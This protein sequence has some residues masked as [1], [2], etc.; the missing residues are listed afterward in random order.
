MTEK[1]P[2][3]LEHQPNGRLAYFKTG[4]GPP[5][6]V[7]MAGLMSDMAGTKALFLEHLCGEKGWGYV[8][9]DYTGHGRSGG[10][11][12]AGTI[13]SWHRDTLKVIDQVTE[14]PLVVVGSS[15][16]GWQALLAALARPDRVKGLI[17]LAPA[18]DFTER[19]LWP[20]LTKRQKEE[21]E[22]NGEIHVP[23]DYGDDPYIFTKALFDDGR[24][25]LLLD[26]PIRLDL[27]VRLI[28]GLADSDVP[29]WLSEEIIARLTSPDASLT[30]IEGAGH[31]LSNEDQLKILR[32]HLEDVVAIIKHQA[33]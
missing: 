13:G 28:H 2:S 4:G 11:F 23:S 15:M 16:G 3:Y 25:H 30:L 21:L 31:S 33:L 22:K 12:K 17:G 10:T 14:G 6:V 8:R 20:D 26:K 19:L 18:P 7:F 24:K 9:F 27:P 29:H 1:E 32:G 5:T